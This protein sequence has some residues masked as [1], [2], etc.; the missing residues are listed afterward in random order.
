MKV[1]NVNSSSRKTEN[2]IKETFAMLMKEKHELNNITVTELVTRA[3]ITRS[4][5]Y[6]HYDSI[7][8]LARE[9]QD[10]TLD[11][12]M[13]GTD[14]IHDLAGLNAYFDKVIKHL[15]ENETFYR[16][17]LASDE[18]L[19]FTNKLNKLM[20]SK[21]NDFFKDNND[22][23]TISFFADG[24]ISL[25]IKHF[26]GNDERTLDEINQFMKDVFKKLFA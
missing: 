22:G 2:I 12:L 3:N 11:F 23:L 8:D 20:S 14:E 6:T 17:L 10:E 5:F 13:A 21:L 1:K 16:M 19:L 26:R 9:I 7:Y 4:S 18:P 15:K 25:L 24:C